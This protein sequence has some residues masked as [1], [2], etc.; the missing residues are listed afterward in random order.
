LINQGAGFVER[1]RP[2]GSEVFLGL[3]Y[4]D[5]LVRGELAGQIIGRIHSNT[6][7]RIT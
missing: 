1:A 2:S 5:E 4:E 3:F 6:I 7:A